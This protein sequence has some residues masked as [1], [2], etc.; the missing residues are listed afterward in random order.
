MSTH[1]TPFVNKL[2]TPLA[3]VTLA[4]NATAAIAE[5]IVPGEKLVGLAAHATVRYGVVGLLLVAN[6]GFCMVIVMMYKT[7]VNL[8]L[9]LAATNANSIRS[10]DALVAELRARPCIN[11]Q[12]VQQHQQPQQFP[13]FKRQSADETPYV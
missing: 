13:Q 10:V 9:K 7:S 12:S 8:A 2:F 4:G 5:T 11:T 6:L 1:N 3:M